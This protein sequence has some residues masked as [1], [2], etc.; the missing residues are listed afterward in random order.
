[1]D[2]TKPPVTPSNRVASLKRLKNVLMDDQSSSSSSI[3]S[4]TVRDETVE[5]ING[6]NNSARSRDQ[7]RQPRENETPSANA[8]RSAQKIRARMKATQST[9]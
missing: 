7:F 5:E 4:V 3:T 6:V 1:M 2:I 9:E 8:S